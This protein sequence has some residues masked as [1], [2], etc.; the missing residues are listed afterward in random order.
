LMPGGGVSSCGPPKI[1]LDPFLPVSSYRNFNLDHS[2]TGSLSANPFSPPAGEDKE[3]PPSRGRVVL[4]KL[5][6]VEPQTVPMKFIV[7]CVHSS[8]PPR[9]TVSS[10]PFFLRGRP[11]PQIVSRRCHHSVT[12][13]LSDACMK[14]SFY[15]YLLPKCAVARPPASSHRADA[16][17][18]ARR[19]ACFPQAPK[20]SALVLFF[21]KVQDKFRSSPRRSGLA[22]VNWMTGEPF[23]LGHFSHVELSYDQVLKVRLAQTRTSPPL[24][25]HSLSW[26]TRHE[27]SWL[28]LAL[29][30][31]KVKDIGGID[32]FDGQIPWTT[33]TAGRSL[34][35]PG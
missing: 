16:P 17:R 4:P 21:A 18:E 11:H 2:G 27:L 6:I 22:L 23:V 29:Q 24:I 34:L 14:N 20:R 33:S 3:R 25:S 5:P 10:T 13:G 28:H 31:L 9:I 26:E 19:V 8:R 30:R 35:Y 12:S 32:L 7:E 15:V 1:F